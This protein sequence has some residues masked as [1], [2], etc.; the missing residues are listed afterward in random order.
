MPLRE[1]SVKR[2]S[3]VGLQQKTKLFV[4]G[5]KDCI[6]IVLTCVE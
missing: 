4:F 6:T 2:K 1:L 5:S 3:E